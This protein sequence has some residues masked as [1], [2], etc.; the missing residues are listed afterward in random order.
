[1]Q[2]SLFDLYTTFQERTSWTSK[3]IEDGFS[4]RLGVLEETI[5]DVNLIEISRKHSDYVLTRKFGRRE[6]GSESGADWLW[7][8]G[9]PGAWFSVLA[10]AKVINPK[11]STCHALNY[12]SGDQRRLL[13]DFARRHRLFPIYCLYS[14]I[15]DKSNPLSKSLPSLS[16]FDA[17]EWACALVIP[18]FVRQ[19]VDQKH[20]KQQDLLRYGIPWT[21][22]FYHAMKN[23]DQRLAYS[24]AEA[25]K[26]V[27]AEFSVRSGKSSS[28]G[29]G[30]IRWEN[31]DPTLL[32]N[33]NLPN[34]VMRLLKG[35]ISSVKSPLAGVS[36]ISCVPIEIALNAQNIL[37]V[38]DGEF[39]LQKRAD[40]NYGE[41]VKLDTPKE[42]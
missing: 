40:E 10:Q 5:T 18:K 21:F 17:S 41:R 20:K 33:P 32:I 1:M 16:S 36:V 29:N 3:I 34:V 42:N 22:P 7:C 31:P 11:T 38:A 24:L 37:P 8:I 2:L 30:R 25:L 27:G 6:E 28:E 15:T 39:F 13:L 35:K 19:L 12:R 9:E 14:Q 26:K 4:S 23:E